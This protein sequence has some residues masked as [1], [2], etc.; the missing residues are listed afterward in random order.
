MPDGSLRWPLSGLP[1]DTAKANNKIDYNI[2]LDDHGN[3]TV[4]WLITDQYQHTGKL[5]IQRLDTAGTVRWQ[6]G[7][8][9]IDSMSVA[10]SPLT[11]C[12]VGTK[13]HQVLAC[14]P[15]S[16]NQ[17]RAQYLDSSGVLSWSASGV[18]INNGPYQNNMGVQAVAD[19]SGGA[20]V[21]FDGYS[22][23][24][25]NGSQYYKRHVYA[26][27]LNSGGGLGSGILTAVRT[28]KSPL[29]MEFK[30]QQ[31]YPNP[32]NPRTTIEYQLP[33]ASN[34][35]LKIYNVLGQVVATLADGAINAGYQSA[36]WNANNFASGIYFY[37]IEAT[38]ISDP[39]KRF[40]QVK[41]M[42]LIK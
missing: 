4:G 15:V 41:K 21:V 33:V 22:A 34:V 3:I 40:T 6:P 18:P 25:E 39:G 5:M 20:I 30:L 8:I 35:S 2:V 31:N 17:F 9:S 13:T 19:S 12:L 36:H 23:V 26:Q 27:R 7:G 24:S 28:K 37:R 10:Y 14:Y 16:K 1:I 42:L 11:Y 32:F 38:S 29:P